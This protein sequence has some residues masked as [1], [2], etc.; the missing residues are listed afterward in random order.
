VECILTR[1]N[2]LAELTFMVLKRFLS[3]HIL[4]VYL[5]LFFTSALTLLMSGHGI[6]V[7]EN[8]IAQTVE[9][10]V[11]RGDLTVHNMYQALE[12]ADGQ[13]YSRYGITFPL[14]MVLFYLLGY[15]LEWIAG[16][17]P[18][19]NAPHFF[20]MLWGS[21]LITAF[22]GCLFFRICL[23]LSKDTGLSLLFSLSLIFSTPFL[24]YSQTL[25]RM[26]ASTALL[27]LLFWLVL[28]L[29]QKHHGFHMTTLAL[30]IAAGLNLRED[31]LLFGFPIALY[32][33]CSGSIRQKIERIA[34]IAAGLLLGILIWGGHN[35][36]RFGTLFVEN[37]ADITF[38]YPL[39]ISVPELLWGKR[40]LLWYAPLMLLLPVALL[41]L[42][43]STSNND[44]F[45][46]PRS[47][48][49]TAHH[50]SYHR[51][52]AHNPLY[53]WMMCSAVCLSALFLYGKSDMWHGGRC[54]GPRYLY[55]LLP[56]AMLPGIYLFQRWNS[57][58]LRTGFILA[59]AWGTYAN[60]SGVYAHQGDYI[61][62]FE[63]PSFL[64]LYHNLPTHPIYNTPADLDLWWIRMLKMH[65]FSLWSLTFVLLCLLT[66]YFLYAIMQNQKNLSH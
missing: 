36:I 49:N 44:L 57:I 48:H 18:F 1:R 27:L 5:F 66:L 65:P 22:T 38:N 35:Y 24:P 14:L 19:F 23:H 25:Y 51:N 11:T 7:D 47:H 28:K 58:W 39:I 21:V 6:F 64:E 62:F 50:S 52:P 9:S 53:I 30:V 32:T 37:Y 54:W 20:S 34:A 43:K 29:Q 12:G 16:A 4:D 46:E 59:A 45:H 33:I 15:L 8:L 60:W 17:A 2:A 63:R 40:G 42:R 13:Y 3:S 10:I 31:L 26:T 41:A 55:F 61:S 56:F